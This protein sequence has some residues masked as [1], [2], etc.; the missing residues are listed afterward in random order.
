[1]ISVSNIYHS[2]NL[3][4][5]SLQVTEQEMIPTESA[6]C[7]ARC[8]GLLITGETTAMLRIGSTDNPTHSFATTQTENINQFKQMCS[9]RVQCANASKKGRRSS[10]FVEKILS[11]RRLSHS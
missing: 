9:K 8:G 1:M 4:K 10:S 2:S 11:M 7:L 6:W 3:T 5:G